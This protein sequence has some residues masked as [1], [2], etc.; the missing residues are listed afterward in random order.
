MMSVHDRRVRAEQLLIAALCQQS[1]DKRAREKLLGDLSEHKFTSHELELIFRTLA[2]ISNATPIQ[3]R[4]LLMSRLTRLGFPDIDI[5]PYFDGL[6]P[7]RSAEI[8]R[9]LTDL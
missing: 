1:V 4:E 9:L 2:K 3:T 5:E 8:R 7:P 6:E